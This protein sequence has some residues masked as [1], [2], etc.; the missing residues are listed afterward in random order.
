MLVEDQQRQKGKM[1]SHSENTEQ[2]HLDS[3]L[4][5][6]LPQPQAQAPLP[7]SQ[8]NPRQFSWRAVVDLLKED[9][10]S[11]NIYAWIAIIIVVLYV[12]SP[13]DFIPDWFFPLGLIDDLF[14][15]LWLIYYLVDYI[16]N[17]PLRQNNNNNQHR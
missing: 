4:Q 5:N 13:I 12:I 8:Q 9:L 1:L 10:S 11:R 7:A 15:I 17:T 2:N 14:A 3:K 6:L 16:K